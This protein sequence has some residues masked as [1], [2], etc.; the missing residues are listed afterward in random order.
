MTLPKNRKNAAPVASSSIQGSMAP[1]RPNSSQHPRAPGACGHTKSNGVACPVNGRSTF[2]SG[3]VISVCALCSVVLGARKLQEQFWQHQD[4]NEYSLLL[5]RASSTRALSEVPTVT[6]AT[7]SILPVFPRL[8]SLSTDG[9][10]SHDLTK[11]R[12]QESPDH[13]AMN[14]KGRVTDKLA[15]SNRSVD[16]ESGKSIPTVAT[17]L[18]PKNVS[19]SLISRKAPPVVETD[20]VATIDSAPLALPKPDALKRKSQPAAALRKPRESPRPVNQSNFVKASDFIYRY[21]AEHWDSSPIVVEKYK[22]VFFT[23]PKVACT[24][25]KQLLRR[26]EGFENWKLQDGVETFIPHNP[27]TN[28][29]KYLYNYSLSEASEIMTSPEW[30]RAIMVRDPKS[31]FLSAFLDKAV[32]NWGTHMRYHCCRTPQVE[33]QLA[34]DKGLSP[35]QEQEENKC[36]NETQEMPGFLKKIRTCDDDHWR[37]QHDRMESKYWPYMTQVLH[38]ENAEEDTKELLERLGVF[39]EF[40][41]RGVWNPDTDRAIFESQHVSEVGVHVTYSQFQH[42]KWYTPALEKIVEE[43]YASDYENP[44]LNFTKSCLTCIQESNS[45]RTASAE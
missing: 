35:E 43:F 39:Y 4:R 27:A 33:A 5:L 14:D 11:L 15:V 10:H 12:D 22:L 13:P 37:P 21:D 8:Y 1:S 6:T 19:L 31:R 25:W 3:V 24:V 7:A 36:V 18:A 20:R 41:A 16:K 26:M 29:L 45:T 2:I 42:W 30:T 28:G 44:R 38:M 32:S 17:E 9:N 40:G 23:V 34:A